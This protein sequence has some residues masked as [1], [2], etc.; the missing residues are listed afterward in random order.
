[1]HKGKKKNQYTEQWDHIVKKTTQAFRLKTQAIKRI[2][3]NNP[4]SKSGAAGSVIKT[5]KPKVTA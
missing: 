5:K 1:M 3:L 2:M 4:T